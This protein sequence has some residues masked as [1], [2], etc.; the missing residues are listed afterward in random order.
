VSVTDQFDPA[1]AAMRLAKARLNDAFVAVVHAASD[2]RVRLAYEQ[3]Y[4]AGLEHGQAMARGDRTVY[5]RGY[6]AGYS[7]GRR[8][9]PEQLFGAGTGRPRLR[10]GS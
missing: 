2:D 6:S 4:N 3:G 8:G 10:D 5:R 1:S 9:A 7:A